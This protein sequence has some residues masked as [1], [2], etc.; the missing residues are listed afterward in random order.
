MV[1]DASQMSLVEHCG[2]IDDGSL[3]R[4]HAQ[5]LDRCDMGLRQVGELVDGDSEH[6]LGSSDRDAHSW[7]DE[8]GAIEVV[9]VCGRLM[10]DRGIQFPACSM[11]I[12]DMGVYRTG[13]SE[14]AGTEVNEDAI[15]DSSPQSPGR[16]AEG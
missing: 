12:E 5:T 2:E 1:E 13:E 10:G 14:N 3:T 7:L 11:K 4:C 15:C 6:L 8:R 16:H 9:D